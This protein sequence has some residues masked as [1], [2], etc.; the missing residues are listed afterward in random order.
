MPG[1]VEGAIVEG[2]AAVVLDDLLA[3]PAVRR[4]LRTRPPSLQPAIEEA[5]TAIRQA[6]RAYNAASAS[7]SAEAPVAE[8][9]QPFEKGITTREA[10]RLLGLGERRARQLATGGMG[11]KVGRQWLLDAA[12][13]EEYR[14]RT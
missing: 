12:A 3:I 6:A 1:Y 14:R 11:R 7:G 4:H 8:I 5:V 9:V 13:V 2:A 10:A